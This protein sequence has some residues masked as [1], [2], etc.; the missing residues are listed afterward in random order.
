M[1][2]GLTSTEVL[3]ERLFTKVMMVSAFSLSPTNLSFS[4]PLSLGLLSGLLTISQHGEMVNVWQL[5]AKPC[6][7]ADVLTSC[8]QSNSCCRAPALSFWGH[9]FHLVAY[10]CFVCFFVCL[11]HSAGFHVSFQYMFVC[12]QVNVSFLDIQ[13][14]LLESNLW[15][16]L[17]VCF[18]AGPTNVF[19]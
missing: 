2:A 13:L 3:L 12:V 17:S 5:F 9:C 11:S 7:R 4:K 15:N 16:A 6:T 8:L 10:A 1:T 19:I 14:P 18:A